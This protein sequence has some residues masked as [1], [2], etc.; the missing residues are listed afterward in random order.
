MYSIHLS[1]IKTI[2]LQQW[3]YHSMVVKSTFK[4]LKQLALRHPS[5]RQEWMPTALHIF[6]QRIHTETEST[7]III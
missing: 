1:I 2:I 6:L 5:E 4:L 3:S 7:S